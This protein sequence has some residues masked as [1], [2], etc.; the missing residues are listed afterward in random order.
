MGPGGLD[1]ATGGLPAGEV[2]VGSGQG[3]NDF[4]RRGY[5][6]P[7]PPPGHGTHHYRFTLYALREPIT[8]ADDVTIAELG[9]AMEGSVP[10]EAA[11]VGTYER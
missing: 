7:C 10:A 11:L 2:A 4:G 5:G 6:G 1:P 3:R 9:R 8:P